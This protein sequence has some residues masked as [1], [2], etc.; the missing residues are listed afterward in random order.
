MF[1]E[2]WASLGYVGL[3]LAYFGAPGLPKELVQI[4]LEYFGTAIAWLKNRPEVD[5]A[6]IGVMGGSRGGEA[7]LL[8]AANFADLS[9]AVAIVPSG[10]VWG[11]VTADL[12]AKAAWTLGGK[13]VAYMPSSGA[14]PSAQTVNGKV[15]YTER[16]MFLADLAA[17]SSTA[18]EA[19]TIPVEK[20]HASILML[21][22][23]DD[24]LWA[25]CVLAKIA[26]DRLVAAGHTTTH[27][28]D[29]VCYPNAGHGFGF[30]DLPTADSS[31]FFAP[32][33]NAWFELGGTPA[34]LAHAA[35]EADTRTRRF[36]AQTLGGK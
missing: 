34:G 14:Q 25:S 20:A 32:D 29:Y 5:P 22:G 13:D 26:Q 23:D 7:A 1:A 3:G 8:L 17:A 27:A 9:A 2:Y 16:P 36:L 30:P 15:V 6:R 10:V 12:S 4:P 19:A 21:A 18:L 11:G 24:Q 33:I 31:M 35:R 28:D